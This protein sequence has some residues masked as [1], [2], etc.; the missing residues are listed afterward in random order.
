LTRQLNLSDVGKKAK[1][2]W[3]A[4]ATYDQSFCFAEITHGL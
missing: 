4:L 3:Q 2:L 1:S